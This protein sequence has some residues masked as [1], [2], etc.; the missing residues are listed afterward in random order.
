MFKIGQKGIIVGDQA[1]HSFHTGEVVSVV[2][3]HDIYPSRG[4]CYR[5]KSLTTGLPR[6]VFGTYMKLFVEDFQSEVFL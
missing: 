2:S 6:Y 5:C 4:G 3:F 1:H